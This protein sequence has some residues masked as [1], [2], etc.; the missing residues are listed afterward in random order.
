MEK[1]ALEYA[2]ELAQPHIE[3]IDGEV[4]SDKILRR[5]HSTAESPLRSESEKSCITS[6]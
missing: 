3:K 2:V 5:I 4:Y 1:E 6:A